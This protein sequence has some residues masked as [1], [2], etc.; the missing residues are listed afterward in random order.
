MTSFHVIAKPSSSKCNLDCKYC[1]YNESVK[2][3]AGD[4]TLATL[5]EF[6]KQYIRSQPDAPEVSFTWQGGEPTL[7]GLGF[8]R[9]AADFQTKYAREGQCISNVLQTN[10]VLL[11]NEW[12]KFLK[13]EGWLV[14]LSVDGTSRHHD[15]YRK[16]HG[17]EGSYEQV[18][19][20]ASL[21]RNHKVAYNTLTCVSSVNQSHGTE[22]YEWLRDVTRSTHMQFIPIVGP[23]EQ[24]TA[25]GYGQFM[26]DVFDAWSAADWGK[27]S[28]DYFE[29]QL[30]IHAGM[31][32][33]QCILRPACGKALAIEADGSV[34]SCDHYVDEE[35]RVGSD[36]ITLKRSVD[37]PWQQEFGQNKFTKLP[38]YCMDCSMLK[39]CYGGCPKNRTISTPDGEPGLN[40]LC[41]GYRKIFAHTHH[42]LRVAAAEV[43]IGEAG[44]S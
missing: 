10:G 20:A 11:N 21:L 34:Y 35:H 15:A 29:D 32:P 33:H 40:Y 23:A 39:H 13:T 12:A 44:R 4:M 27:V 8:Y 17:G 18:H 42:H 16:N 36:E 14:G 7:R 6:V 1:F 19:R 43:I 3:D 30:A 2:P 24:C 38:R 22:T 9:E 31:S 5:R 37:S 26:C 41:D 25:E 28:V